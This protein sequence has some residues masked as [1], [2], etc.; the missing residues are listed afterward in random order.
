MVFKHIQTEWKEGV[1]TLTLNRAPLN[2][3]NIEMMEEIN[4]YFEGLKKEKSL[5][6]LVIQAIGKAFSAGV[7]VGEHMGDM[8]P[9]M[10]ETFHKMFRFMD[11]LKVPSLALVNGSA[12]GGGCEL[13]LYCDMVIATER[14][15][16]G[17]PEIQVGVFPPIAALIFPRLIGRK[18]A[19]ELI[20]TGETIGAQEARGLGLVNKVVSEASLSQEASAF[21]EK[22]KKLSGIVLKLTKEAALKGLNDDLDGGLKAIE[23]IYLDRLMK[24]HDA[25]EGLQAFL[26]KRK[27]TWREE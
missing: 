27:P 9:K 19:M 15:K 2:V 5:K 10:I 20:L 4:T 25:L 14:A 17:Q 18:K 13:A 6:L 12:L 8:A 23:K 3:L 24:S 1:A 22:F 26:E 21:I 11:A 7:D 16:F